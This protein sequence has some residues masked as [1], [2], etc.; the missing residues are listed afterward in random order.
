MK[1][2]NFLRLILIIQVLGFF[3]TRSNIYY[4]NTEDKDPIQK[5]SNISDL[6]KQTMREYKYENYSGAPELLDMG[7]IDYYEYIEEKLK[8]LDKKLMEKT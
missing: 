3:S 6:L 1:T 8:E 7:Y 4:I 5:Q 2:S